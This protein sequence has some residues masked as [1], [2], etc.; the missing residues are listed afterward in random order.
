MVSNIDN[1]AVEAFAE[2]FEHHAFTLFRD[3][4]S[5]RAKPSR[6]AAAVAGVD[7]LQLSR[8]WL[9]FLFWRHSTAVFQKRPRWN[10]S[11][12]H[13]FF[14]TAMTPKST[15]PLVWVASMKQLSAHGPDASSTKF[16][17]WNLKLQVFPVSH[18]VCLLFVCLFRSTGTI[19][20]LVTSTMTAWC[21][22]MASIDKLRDGSILMALQTSDASRRSTRPVAPCAVKS[23]WPFVLPTLCGLWVPSFLGTSTT[24][25][26]SGS[27]ASLTWLRETSKWKPTMAVLRRRLAAWSSPATSV[28]M[29]SRNECGTGS[30]C[31]IS[32]SMSA[33]T[34]GA[35][36]PRRFV[37]RMLNTLQ[38][39]VLLLFSH[40]LRWTMAK[41]C[42][43][44]NP[45]AMTISR[46]PASLLNSASRWAQQ[47]Q[48]AHHDWLTINNTTS[49]QKAG[50]QNDNWQWE[51]STMT[52]LAAVFHN[53][54]SSESTDV[55][56]AC[57]G[58]SCFSSEP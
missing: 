57:S 33:S 21:Q 11:C 25:R 39:S 1:D 31:A 5:R 19:A 23:P 9:V 12:G 38:H 6:I 55:C 56:L 46:M 53:I 20:G 17:T 2:Q 41:S 7:V 30:V 48:Q 54:C 26:S 13:H 49:H 10:A 3:G 44:M 58:T 28:S 40:S 36:F 22:S 14:F 45:N 18:L 27:L 15:M 32:P 29:K 42:W 51:R 4:R 52:L 8:Q 37:V 50:N 47:Q 35:F 16:W 24:F 34:T 43:W